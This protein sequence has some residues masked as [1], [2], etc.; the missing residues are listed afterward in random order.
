M[1]IL[2]FGGFGFIAHN[3]IPSLISKENEEIMTTLTYHSNNS[4]NSLSNHEDKIKKLYCDITDD[5]KVNSII[6]DEE[7]DIIIHMASSRYLEGQSAEIQL[8]INV[9]G[10]KNVLGSIK[11]NNKTRLIFVNS[12]IA[13]L[14]G[15]YSNNV[16]F[17]NYLNSKKAASELF[18]KNVQ[19]GFVTGSELRLSTTY[20]PWD[21]KN[22]LVIST[23]LYVASGREIILKSPHSYRD[24]IYIDDIV[25]A[26]NKLINKPFIKADLLEL[27]SGKSN[28][29]FQ[30]V[31][32]INK[33]MGSDFKNNFDAGKDDKMKTIMKSDNSLAKKLL[34]WS[35]KVKIDDGLKNTINWVLKNRIYYE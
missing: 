35:P 3:L 9:K 33:F 29:V 31:K 30:I 27:S 34:S 16:N 24:F 26:I 32:K 21:Y 17:N 5:Y 18:Q 23:I 15:N 1:K 11:N 10:F 28:S 20:G 22:R 14:S 7:P 12:Y 6:N 8:D 19:E 13:N 25:D 4:L 2:I